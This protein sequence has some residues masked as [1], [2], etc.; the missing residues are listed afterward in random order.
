MVNNA[1][2][3]KIAE[4]PEEER[5]RTPDSGLTTE[6]AVV[7][8]SRAEDGSTDRREGEDPS[9]PNEA[10][11]TQD[12][13]RY[14]MQN[15]GRNERQH[16]GPGATPRQ[17]HSSGRLIEVEYER[18]NGNRSGRVHERS[19][20]W[21]NE[22]SSTTPAGRHDERPRERLPNEWPRPRRRDEWP[23]ENGSDRSDE[24][25][26]EWP[27]SRRDESF[28]SPPPERLALRRN[29][30]LNDRQN[31]TLDQGLVER[32]N[33]RRDDEG[34]EFLDGRRLRKP[35][36]RRNDRRADRRKDDLHRTGDESLLERRRPRRTGNQRLVV[37]VDYGTTYSGMPFESPTTPNNML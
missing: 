4:K 14:D 13:R 7:I 9:R 11:N 22:M 30:R 25:R 37:A 5:F 33:E 26:N 8:N 17:R 32:R 34:D 27:D 24:R 21:P 18:P 10:R 19:D 2:D 35:E 15:V 3:E 31:E 23:D 36:D 20:E 1:Q 16:E 6:K 29:Q 28:E 12:E